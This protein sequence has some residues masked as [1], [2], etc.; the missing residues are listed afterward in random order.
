MDY[1]NRVFRAVT[2]AATGDVGSETRF[3]YHQSGHVVWGTYAG[4]SVAFGTLI[5]TKLAD[6]RLNMRYQ[7]V[8]TEGLIKTGRCTSTPEVLDDGRVR[9][10]E[11]WTW[12]EGG[13]GDGQSC[14][15]EAPSAADDQ[16]PPLVT[17][18]DS[19]AHYEWGE[20][21]VGWRL[22]NEPDLTVIEERMP[23]GSAE[24]LHTHDRAR[25]LFFVLA[26]H[27]EIVVRGKTRVL[28]TGE[29]LEIPPRMAHVVKNASEADVSFL[30]V[31]A[32]STRDDRRDLS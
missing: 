4:G 20:A 16:G 15:E 13:N 7:H 30:V 27:L 23:P 5:A 19:A 25:Q 6:G 10:H 21:C 24:R 18:R 17:S 11:I 31:S 32:P 29:S 14:V 26:G 12:T 2:N 1:S 3:H 28:R 9:L 22:L 8:T